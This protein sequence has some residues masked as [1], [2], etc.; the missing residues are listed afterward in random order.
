MKANITFLFT[1]SFQVPYHLLR[2]DSMALGQ[3]SLAVVDGQ[4][5]LPVRGSP[6]STFEQRCGRAQKTGC[7][8]LREGKGDG[9][10]T[11][12]LWL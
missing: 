2:Q 4:L 7:L 9:L 8:L 3:H 12:G 10:E 11:K 6:G 5:A 1:G